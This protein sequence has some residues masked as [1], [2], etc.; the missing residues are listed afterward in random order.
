MGAGNDLDS[1]RHC[2]HDITDTFSPADTIVRGLAVALRFYAIVPVIVSF[3]RA[4]TRVDTEVT[5]S[6]QPYQQQVLAGLIVVW[7]QTATHYMIT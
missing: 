6:I 4:L 3:L 7:R 5:R 2:Q 1:E